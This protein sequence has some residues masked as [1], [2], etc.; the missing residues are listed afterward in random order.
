M[1]RTLTSAWRLPPLATINR[2]HAASAVRAMPAAALG[3]LVNGAIVVVTLWNR[4]PHAELLLWYAAVVAI[5]AWQVRPRPSL[6]AEDRPLNRRGLRR[7]M[8]FATVVASPWLWL[9]V[10]HLGTLPHTSELILVAIC[11][12]MAASGS[13][14]MAPVYP[15][16]L[17]YMATILIPAAVKCFLLSLSGYAPLGLL[18]VSY[19]AFLYAVIATNAQLLAERSGAMRALRDAGELL[20]QRDLELEAQNLKL[21]AA[22]ENMSQGLVMY[23]EEYRVVVANRRFA[24]LYDLSHDQVRAGTTLREVLERRKAKGHYGG[25]TVEEVMA[26]VLAKSEGD[27]VRQ[28]VNALPGGRSVAVSSRPMANGGYVV[29]LEDVTQQR[30]LDARIAHLATHDALTGVAN[31]TLFRDNLDKAVAAVRGGDRGVA[32]MALDLNKFKQVNDTLG[33]P[34]GDAL[35]QEVARRLG[36]CVREEDGVARLGG[37][38]FAVVLHGRDPENEA[39]VLASRMLLAVSS[40]FPLADQWVEVGGSIGIAVAN[41]VSA[42]AE[43][44]IREA[45]I[46]LYRA[47]AEGGNLYRLYEPSMERRAQQVA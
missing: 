27:Q 32:L 5:A 39:R 43:R 2:D 41:G 3:G 23:D 45:D 31:R 15:A 8:I 46:A 25:K 16:A 37:D 12:G 26:A 40:P 34:V 4:V 35:L 7:S 33:H 42:D 11:C 14:F 18:A 6:Q 28:Y 10:T 47:K 24:E 30:R 20:R 9:V 17:I 19:A 13:V 36:K 38:E 22:L 29:T 44:L 21:D 1:R